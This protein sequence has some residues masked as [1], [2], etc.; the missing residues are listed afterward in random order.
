MLQNLN[1]N[2]DIHAQTSALGPSLAK[3]L[4][5]MEFNLNKGYNNAG[6]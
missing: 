2:S 6:I 5:Y 1:S 4:P 3:L